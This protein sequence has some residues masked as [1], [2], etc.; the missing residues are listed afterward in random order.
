[1]GIFDKLF[2]SDPAGERNV[3]K[4]VSWTPLVHPDQLEK[5]I[6]DSQSRPQVIFKHSTSCGISSMVLRRFEKQG[7]ILGKQANFLFL[8]LHSYREISNEVAQQFQVYHQS[9]QLLII[10]NGITVAHAS[11]YEINGLHLEKYL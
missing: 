3:Q 4:D 5:V 11:H 8:D 2:G 10:K 9:P 6:Q 7:G 1:M